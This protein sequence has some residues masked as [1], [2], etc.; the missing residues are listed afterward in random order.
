MVRPKEQSELIV[1]SR[2]DDIDPVVP[3]RGPEKSRVT[4][5]GIGKTC[6]VEIV[7]E[8]FQPHR[9]IVGE[10]ILKAAA[11]DPSRNGI[12]KCYRGKDAWD[13]RTG[14]A[15]HS[16]PSTAAGHIDEPTI[17]GVARLPAM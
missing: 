5:I 7:V 15:L 6:V 4:G 11:D 16:A 14:S 10:G 17:S 13:I 1:H 12:A 2:P 3:S 8:T 9:P